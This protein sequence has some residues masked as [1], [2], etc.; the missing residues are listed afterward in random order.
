MNTP[1]QNDGLLETIKEFA[2]W[3]HLNEM[4]VAAGKTPSDSE[5]DFE[6][7]AWNTIE[8]AVAASQSAAMDP[9]ILSRLAIGKS[10][11]FDPATKSFHPEDDGVVGGVTYEPTSWNYGMDGFDMEAARIGRAAFQRLIDLDLASD[12]SN[13]ADEIIE[14]LALL[15]APAN[16]PDMEELARLAKAA[17]KAPYH[18][19]TNAR[20]DNNWR[21]NADFQEAA[22][23]DA[24]LALIAA[25]SQQRELPGAP[26]Q[27]VDA[28]RTEG[29]VQ[30]LVA[31]LA[32]F[33]KHYEYWM[34]DWKDDKETSSYSRHTFGDL[35]NAR[36]LIDEANVRGHHQ[37]EHDGL[38]PVTTAP[39]ATAILTELSEA[40]RELAAYASY[41][42]IIGAIGHNK[43]PIRKWCDE[44]FRLSHQLDDLRW[45]AE[46]PEEH[47]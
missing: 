42:E 22:S 37:A 5:I 11:V 14:A 36:K 25:V 21:A 30:R 26:L 18:I 19:Y 12:T 40:A 44:V 38:S 35:R 29:L 34:D 3:H 39:D 23:P 6:V 43:T 7:A 45:Q 28:S 33:T 2:R 46:N 1:A 47:A 17:N 27:A 13:D 31:S 4:T 10:F 41:A 20:D 15:H 24:V 32:V 16:V 9:E 8:R